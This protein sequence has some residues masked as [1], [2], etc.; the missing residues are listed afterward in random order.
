VI[1]DESEF[2][3]RFGR[4]VRHMSEA[5]LDG[6]LLDDSEALHYFTG[7][8]ISLTNYRALIVKSDGTATFVLRKLDVAPLV[9]RTWVRN[10]VGYSDWDS[11]SEAIA[12]AV[13]DMGLETGRMGVSLQSHA[14]TVDRFNAFKALLPQVTFIDIGD[15]PLSWRKRKS[16]AEIAKLKKAGEVADRAIRLIVDSATIGMTERD[17]ARMAAEAYLRFGADGGFLGVITSGKDWDFLH[18]HLHDTPLVDGDI[19]H[20]ELVPRVDGY[21][22]R[23]MRCVVMGEITEEQNEVARTLIALQDAQIAA[24]KP[25]AIARDIDAIVRDGLLSSGLRTSYDNVT[26]YTTGWYSDYSIRGSDFTWIFHP[27]ADWEVEEDMVFH[28]YTSA[29][30]IAFSETVVVRPG[31]GERLTLLERK[32]FSTAELGSE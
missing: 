17:A 9:E 24:L 15:L 20:I 19:L 18:G 22:A 10:V 11:A 6:M 1:F 16:P 31:G 26:G 27:K 28:M 21:S 23:L 14:M 2:E 29:R 12:R 7:F 5:G 32:L 13:C 25:G 3:S 30:G 4:L 8:D